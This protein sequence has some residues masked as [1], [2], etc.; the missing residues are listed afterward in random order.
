MSLLV[1]LSEWGAHVY[2]FHVCLDQTGG[3]GFMDCF[4]YLYHL[5]EYNDFLV[6]SH[7]FENIMYSPKHI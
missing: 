5:E 1:L 4:S 3:G 7:N 6:K 2:L